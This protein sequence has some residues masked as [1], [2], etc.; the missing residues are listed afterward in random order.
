MSIIELREL[1]SKFLG[2]SAQLHRLV[3]DHPDFEVIQEP[4]PYL[5]CFRY[6]PNRLSER[7]EEPAVENWLDRLNQEIVE[8]VRRNGSTIVMT[9]CIR[10]RIAIRMFICSH[11]TSEED[12]DTT[13]EAIARWGRC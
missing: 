6:V 12:I 10:G 8:A 2:L 9:T 1:F 5:Y 3:C 4:T 13:F 11:Q 7:R